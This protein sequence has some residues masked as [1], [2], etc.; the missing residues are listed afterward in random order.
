QPNLP[1][2]PDQAVNIGDEVGVVVPRQ[3][4]TQRDVQYFSV[5]EFFNG[6]G[7]GALPFSSGEFLTED[8]NPDRCFDPQADSTGPDFQNSTRHRSGNLDPLTGLAAE[9]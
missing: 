2:L 9:D 6:Y 5:R 4:A 7:H 8:G 3:F 1:V